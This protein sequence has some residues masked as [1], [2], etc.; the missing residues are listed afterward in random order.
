MIIDTHAHF[1]EEVLDHEAGTQGWQLLEE[2]NQLRAR[3]GFP[4]LKQQVPTLK[5][6]LEVMDRCWIEIA[7]LHQLSF[8]H[9]LSYETLSNEEISKAVKEYPDRLVGFAGIDPHAEDRVDQLD[10]AVNDLGLR[11]LKMNPNDFGAYF[12]ND[13]EL[14]YPLYEKALELNLPVSFHTGITPAP[15]FHMKHNYPVLLDDVAVDFP[16]LTMIVEHMG[17]PW[18]DLT[19]NMVQ[20]HSNMYLTITATANIMIRQSPVAFHMEMGKM[21]GMIGSKH[22][23][24]GTDWTATPNTEEVLQFLRT[25]EPP[26]P[27]KMM[28]MP[29]LGPTALDDLLG[30]NARRLMTMHDMFKR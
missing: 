29:G 20:R 8:A 9:H 12:P 10:R 24:W 16:D 2:M 18:T 27:M 28:G 25:A 11:G 6:L 7:W 17:F 13:R 22:L 14:C 5:R 30:E 4:P 3:V 15:F 19:Y 1:R 21:L 23:L 26:M